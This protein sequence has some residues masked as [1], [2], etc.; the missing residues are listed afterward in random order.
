M[1]PRR[2]IDRMKSSTRVCAY[3]RAGYGRSDAGPF[4]RNAVRAAEELRVL[5]SRL[6]LV[7]PYVFAGHSLGAVHVMTMAAEHPEIV[8][9]L[10]LLDPPPGVFVTGGRFTNRAKMA[11]E[12]AA[13]FRRT[14]AGARKQNETGKAI[15]YET[16]AS[17]HESLFGNSGEEAEDFQRFWIE[18]NRQIAAMSSRGKFVLAKGSS[19]HIHRDT[20]DLVAREALELVAAARG[21]AR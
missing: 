18:S 14:A 13:E 7:P 10:L 1:S 4:P 16:L 2:D 3:E 12:Q 19:H 11:A 21:A 20:P 8:A 17:E 5:L 6:A 9:A 15:F